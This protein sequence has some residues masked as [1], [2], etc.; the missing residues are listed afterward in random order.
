M[1][2]LISSTYQQRVHAAQDQGGINP[3]IRDAQGTLRWCIRG[4]DR[5]VFFVCLEFYANIMP[6]FNSDAEDDD[7]FATTKASY[8]IHNYPTIFKKV[9]AMTSAQRRVY[10]TNSCN[11]LSEKM[12]KFT[13]HVTYQ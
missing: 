9:C 13:Q 1:S 5:A 6:V 2:A 3:V 11:A 4:P 7:D 10:V 12:L 8:Y